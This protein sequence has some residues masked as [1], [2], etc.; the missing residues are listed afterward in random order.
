MPD[1]YTSEWYESVKSAI[2]AQVT[3]MRN[4]PEGAWT[5][6]VEIVGDGV[7]PY[8]DAGAQRRFL[9]RIEQG[10]C[11]WYREVD[12]EDPEE[13]LDYRFTGPAAVFD[14]IAAGRMDPIDAALQGTVKARGDMRFLLR[15]AELVKVLL[16]SYASGVE[17][18]WPL[19]CPPYVGA[20]SAVRSGEAPARAAV[21]SGEAA[22]A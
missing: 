15:Q 21:R 7:S 16:E 11:A 19:G 2:N 22:N 18:T 4:V 5:V 17:T 14:D 3:T 13:R 1:I 10:Q 8:V 6:A 12:G 20:G 9:V